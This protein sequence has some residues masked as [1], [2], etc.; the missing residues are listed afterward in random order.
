MAQEN[1]IK[2]ES[3]LTIIWSAQWGNTACL[4]LSLRRSIQ[5]D[6]TSEF[7]YFAGI[8]KNIGH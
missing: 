3:S 8:Q 1:S 7:R 2:T 5:P 4:A 6:T